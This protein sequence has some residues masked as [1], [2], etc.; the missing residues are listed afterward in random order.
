MTPGEKQIEELPHGLT[1]R[2]FQVFAE[3]MRE[4][5]QAMEQRFSQLDI[6]LA[7]IHGETRRTNGRVT[8]LEKRMDIAQAMETGADVVMERKRQWH[9]VLVPGAFTLAG[10]AAGAATGAI[11]HALGLW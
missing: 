8:D 2:S 6:K 1:T 11:G 4:N 7:E 5:R 3:W 10:G 9:H